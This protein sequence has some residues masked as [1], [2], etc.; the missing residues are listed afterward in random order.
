MASLFVAPLT[1]SPTALSTLLHL[2]Q[3]DS[4]LD[5]NLG[6]KLGLMLYLL[7]HLL[8]LFLCLLV[9][10]ILQPLLDLLLHL[11]HLDFISLHFSTFPL[12]SLTKFWATKNQNTSFSNFARV[13]SE[14]SPSAKRTQGNRNYI[15]AS[16]YMFYYHWIFPATGWFWWLIFLH[17]SL[18]LLFFFGLI[19]PASWVM[20]PTDQPFSSIISSCLPAVARALSS[21]SVKAHRRHVV[22]HVRKRQRG[23]KKKIKQ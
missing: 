6:L 2:L 13:Y 15:S 11:S 10:L 22:G 1:P 12:S 14:I 8:R 19:S 17:A 7:L 5:L 4:H 20:E 9:N 18:V 3:L 21:V 23:A 16:N